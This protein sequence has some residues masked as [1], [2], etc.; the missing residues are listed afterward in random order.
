MQVTWRRQDES[1]PLTVGSDV[2]ASD[3]TITVESVY[4]STELRNVSEWRLVIHYV[5]LQDEGV[6]HCQVTAK[7]LRR[8]S[9][10][11]RLLVK[12]TNNNNSLIIL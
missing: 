9:F 12:G 1:H 5:R 3:S 2:F 10:E 7:Q 4:P 6:Y 11:V 8:R